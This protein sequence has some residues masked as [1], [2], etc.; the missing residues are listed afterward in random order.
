MIGREI[1]N[2]FGIKEEKDKIK[3]VAN[4]I[5]NYWDNKLDNNPIHR[6]LL[7]PLG[8]RNA[9]ELMALCVEK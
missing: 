5:F 4:K 6:Q 9:D 2:H 8:A 3:E 1:K 7:R